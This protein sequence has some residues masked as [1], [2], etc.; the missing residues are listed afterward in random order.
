MPCC[1]LTFMW[2]SS[3]NTE[4]SEKYAQ[5]PSC[6]TD[7]CWNSCC[8]LTS[9]WSSSYTAGKSCSNGQCLWDTSLSDCGQVSLPFAY[10]CETSCT[11]MKNACI[12]L[13]LSMNQI[14]GLTFTL[15]KCVQLNGISLGIARRAPHMWFPLSRPCH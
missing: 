9:T 10:S 11:S 2:S 12:S 1:L 4:K 6:M 13:P 5:T 7:T 14:R 8:M 3:H 15:L